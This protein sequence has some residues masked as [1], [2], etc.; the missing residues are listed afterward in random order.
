MAN[1]CSVEMKIKGTED[2]INKFYSA[3]TQ[4]GPIWMGRGLEVVLSEDRPCADEKNIIIRFISGQCKWNLQSAL[5][6]DA[7][8]MRTKPEKWSCEGAEDIITLEEACKRW[9]IEMEAYSSEP[10]YGFDEHFFTQDNCFF[11]DVEETKEFYL[12]NFNSKQEAEKEIGMEISDAVWENENFFKIGGYDSCDF[13][14][15]TG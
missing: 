11:T 13:E 12:G 9:N 1:I 4:D 3:L 8:S 2:N 14:I 7:I 6:D 10:E 5:I 15:V